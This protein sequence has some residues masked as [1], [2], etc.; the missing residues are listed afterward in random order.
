M[1]MEIFYRKVAALYDSKRDD[2]NSYLAYDGIIHHHNGIIARPIR[3]G[4]SEARIR[5]TLHRSETAL[6]RLAISELRPG[7]NSRILDA[8]CGRGGNA[9]LMARGSA[10]MRITAINI[11]SYQLSAARKAAGIKK[12]SGRIRFLP[13]SMEDTRFRKASFDRILAC[14]STEHVRLERFFR[15]AARVA[16]PGAKMVVVAW[17]RN[18]KSR[19]SASYAARID[20]RY[21]TRMHGRGDYLSLAGK[22]GWKPVKVIDLTPPTVNYWKLRSESSERTGTEEVMLSAFSKRALLYLLYVYDLIE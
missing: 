14:E 16:A 1:K 21:A 17:T 9:I 4:L 8:G 18:E 20:E 6:S 3:R 5:K 11:S 13:R 10:G 15:E 19:Q 22:N 12:L 7:K 2:L